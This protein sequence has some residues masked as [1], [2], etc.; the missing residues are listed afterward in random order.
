MPGSHS[1]AS[2]LMVEK[3]GRDRRGGIVIDVSL[4]LLATALMMRQHFPAMLHQICGVLFGILIAIHICQHRAW[5]ASLK[6]GKPKGKRLVG[7]FLMA[8]ILACTFIMVA[9]G[10]AMSTWAS[11]LGVP[12]GTGTARALHLPLSH[13]CYCL[14]GMH[15]GLHAKGVGKL[16]RPAVTVW[17]LLAAMGIWSFAALDFRLIHHGHRRLRPHRPQQ[18]STSGLCAVYL[19]VRTVHAGR[20]CPAADP[21]GEGPEF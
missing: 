17:S 1:W 6:Q 11:A 5:I 4:A 18:A 10:L 12:A 2:R 9:S 19:G 21:S 13:L 20:S 8:A 3:Q 14:M 7:A 16:P 15:A